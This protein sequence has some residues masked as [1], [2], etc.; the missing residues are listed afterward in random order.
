MSSKISQTLKRLSVENGSTE[1]VDDDLLQSCDLVTKVEE[2]VPG[3]NPYVLALCGTQRYVHMFVY[4]FVVTFIY[5]FVY[6][7]VYM[8]AY[9][10][11]KS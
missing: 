10:H 3:D 4:I 8:F 5:M 11:F 2:V 6:I 9:L 7:F 1:E